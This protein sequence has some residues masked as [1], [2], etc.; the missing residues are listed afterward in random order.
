MSSKFLTESTG[1]KLRNLLVI[2]EILH[3][4]AYCDSST[5]DQEQT[6]TLCLAGL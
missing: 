2:L 6:R 5:G 3:L 4:L 1:K